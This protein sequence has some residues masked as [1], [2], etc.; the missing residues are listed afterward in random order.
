[1]GRALR[2][3]LSLGILALAALSA[4]AEDYAPAGF[5]IFGQ[6]A[7]GHYSIDVRLDD[8]DKVSLLHWVKHRADLEKPAEKYN[9]RLQF[10]K[11]R[12]VARDGSCLDARGL[13]LQRESLTHIS[14][15]PSSTGCAVV[16]GRWVDPY[17]GEVVE[18]AAKVAVDHLVPLKNAYV[19]GAWKWS[20]NKRCSYFNYQ[21]NNYHLQA[22][23]EREN[24]VKG[25]AGPD[26][27]MPPRRSAQCGYL[28]HWLVIKASW[29]L[30]MSIE[31]GEAIREHIHQVGCTSAEFEIK[32]TELKRIRDEI[33]AGAES[34]EFVSQPQGL[35]PFL[36]GD[37]PAAV[38]AEEFVDAGAGI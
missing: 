15:R 21:K 33:K 36:A 20:V 32:E 3:A 35:H 19:N 18:D 27:Y 13:V 26:R 31:E 4:R 34:C 28:K 37:E 14:T 2:L 6:S 29:D 25:D 5:E 8:D 12:R 24:N 38:P 23:S 10:G 30:T 22:V 9:R 11:W 7:P 17:N 16:S 1:M